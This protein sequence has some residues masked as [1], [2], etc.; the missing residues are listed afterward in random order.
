[1]SDGYQVLMSDLLS[2]AQTFHAES[3]TLS[4][5]E[6]T[7]GVRAP[8]GGDA[9][10]T[11][12]LANAVQAAGLTTGQLGAVVGGH[13]DKLSTATKKYQDA[14][15]SSTQLAQELTKLVGES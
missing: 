5:A 9:A 15:Q 6:S 14:E 12:A 7:A 4:G 11:A 2:M 1:M 8:D 13:G 10:V 3:G